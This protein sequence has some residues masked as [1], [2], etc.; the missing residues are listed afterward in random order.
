MATPLAQRHSAPVPAG[1]PPLS[2]QELARLQGEV[3]DW[4]VRNGHDL[5]RSFQFPDFAQALAFVNRIGAVAEQEQH[6]PD[7]GLGWGRVDVTTFTHSVDGLTEND[8]ILAARIDALG[9]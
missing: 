9:R 4:K 2:R 7:I 6:H 3:P 8:F 5:H 1:T